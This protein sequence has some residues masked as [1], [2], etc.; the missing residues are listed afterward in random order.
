MFTPMYS[1]KRLSFAYA[2]YF[3]CKN[4]MV[5]FTQIP[6]IFAAARSKTQQN[7]SNDIKF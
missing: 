2:N 5:D 6:W 4:Q 1:F 7:I 3:K